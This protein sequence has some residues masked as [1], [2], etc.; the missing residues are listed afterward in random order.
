M[1]LA[2]KG[3]VSEVNAS[4]LRRWP[5]VARG[6]RDLITMH[7]KFVGIIRDEFLAS[8]LAETDWRLTRCC[9]A[10]LPVE[11]KF[12]VMLYGLIG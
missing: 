9:I 10:S 8:P 7:Y 3:S 4:G 2:P 1:D 11:E 6:H 5:S 12:G